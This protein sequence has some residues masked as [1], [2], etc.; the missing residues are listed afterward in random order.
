M[1]DRRPL[2]PPRAGATL[3]GGLA[4]FLVMLVVLFWQ[5]RAGRDPAL[6]GRP[7]AVAAA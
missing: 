2:S 5:V 4:L 3:A 1:T 7:V 6:G